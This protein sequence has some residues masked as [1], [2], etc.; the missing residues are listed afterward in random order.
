MSEKNLNFSITSERL[1]IR[2]F[3]RGDAE[4]FVSFMTDPESTKFLTFAEEQKSREG[5]IELLEATIESYNSESPMMAFAVESQE[6]AQYIGFCGLTP[7]EKGTVEILYAVMPNERSKGYATEIAVT[8][9]AHAISRLGYRRVIA[10]IFEEHKASKGVITKAGFEDRGVIQSLGST[11]M[12]HMFVF[13][14]TGN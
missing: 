6:S 11:E 13:E 2:R 14:K 9:V 4:D 3:E 10:P 8:L 1:R 5:A 7:R 12:V